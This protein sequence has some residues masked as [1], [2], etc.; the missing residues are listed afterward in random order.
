MVLVGLGADTR[1]TR[2]VEF[3]TERRVDISL[4]TFHGYRHA[5]RTLLARQVERVQSPTVFAAGKGRATRSCVLRTQ[6]GPGSWESEDSGRK[7]STR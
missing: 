4:L 3:L 6:S 5:D 2:M 1:A 7:R